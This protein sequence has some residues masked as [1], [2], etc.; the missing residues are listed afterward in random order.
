MHRPAS[1]YTLDRQHVHLEVVTIS[2]ITALQVIECNWR[3]GQ[4]PSWLA[5]TTCRGKQQP[6]E[7]L[8]FLVLILDS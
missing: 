4:G 7:E 5:S 8:I 1:K 6:H 2:P 3:R